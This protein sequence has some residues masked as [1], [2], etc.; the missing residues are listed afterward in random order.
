MKRA[1]G[2]LFLQPVG[3]RI[4]RFISEVLFQSKVI[5]ERPL[6]GF[7]HALVYWGFLAFG[8]ET[9][10]HF[11]RGYGTTFL[12]TGAFHQAF[13]TFVAFFAFL[14]LI[15]I[16][17]LTYRRFVLRPKT[18]GKFSP[19]S[20]TVSAFISILMVTYLAKYF[21]WVEEGTW[22]GQ[23][24]WW[25]HALVILAFL[26][27]IPQSKHLHLVLSPVTTFLK[28]L[29][30]AR[31]RP[32]DFEKEELGAEKLLD[33]HPHTVLGAY[34]CV[35]CGRCKDHCPANST[36]KVLDPKQFILD[37]RR[38]YETEPGGPAVGEFVNSE[39]I[40]Q[41]TTCGACTTQCPV[42]IEHLIPMIELRRGSVMSAGKF[43]APM[44]N[45]FK[46]LETTGN[47]WS[48]DPG[49]AE[50]F[51]NKN[52]VPTY[53]G[54]EV[55][56]WMGC[57]ARY[58]AQYQ[59]TSK[60][61][62]GLL[63]QSGVSWGVLRNETCTG[64][65]ARR[66]GNEFLFQQQARQNI[67]TL[68]GAKPKTIVSTCPHCIWTIEEYKDMGLDSS[69]RVVHHTEF[70]R[71]FVENGKIK[72][73]DETKKLVYHDPCYLS[74]YTDAGGV[75]NPRAVLDHVSKDRV[76]PTRSG[77]RSFCCGAGGAM[78][79]T[80]EKQG[81]RVN[82]ERADELLATGAEV[83]ATGCPFC[84]LMITDAVRDRG[85]DNVKVADIAEILG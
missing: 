47:P 81:K 48:Y 38:G 70:L 33:L 35:E 37:L 40:W 9:V 41:C 74:R 46:G 6:P 28:D 39:A 68:N 69:I 31:I 30:I 20:L 59:K 71:P 13:S 42:G 51:L 72:S 23:V 61:F 67:A 8:L 65:A 21:G 58:D 56:Y 24:N 50:P 17:G 44:A 32:L 85:K 14:V 83:I 12:G 82:H 26:V 73:R 78:L 16:L 7:L 60:A 3:P 79:F 75:S 22:A 43:P 2:T 66:A 49:S 18:L 27:L 63:R 10:D 15:G 5:R 55:L 64:D 25:L 53:G 76:E 62:M 34:S 54:Q 1:K 57:M 84:R 45:L 29:K 80:E 11:A 77:S 52:E 4:G 36:G 19:T